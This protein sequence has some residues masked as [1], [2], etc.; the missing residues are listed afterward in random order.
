[1]TSNGSGS[2]VFRREPRVS[3]LHDPRKEFSLADVESEIRY[4]P[5]TGE[6]SR[7]CHFSLPAAAPSDI[8]AIAE[9]RRPGCPFCPGKVDTV[10]PR[11]PAGL[12]PGGRFRRGEAVV[13]PNLF[14]YDELS[15]V[16]VPAARHDLAMGDVPESLIASGVGTAR[17][18]LALTLPRLGG[19]LL[20][21]VTWNHMPPA[22]GT[23]LHPHMQVV[24]TSEP[25]G[26]VRRELAAESAWLES[27]GRPYVPALL[28]AEEAA[29]RM[30]GRTGA[31]TWYVPFAPTGVLGDCRAVLPGKSSV[32]ELDDGDVAD[33]AAG[34]RRV[35]RGF[36]ATGLWSFNLT[37]VP[38]R[39]GE[40]SGRHALSARLLPRLYIDP[41]LHTPDA[42][43]LHMLLGER[44]SMAWP[45]EVAE[46]LRRSFSEG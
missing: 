34:L 19:D 16:L 43:Y 39:S 25:G 29:G 12:V 20:G 1:M 23:Q 13:F 24:A 9:A 6:S 2:V 44:F 35:L 8:A 18:F 22:G 28:A 26:T 37:F 30:V 33:F 17:D 31:W 45:E 42:N 36:A 14:P 41:V 10:T 21:L 32:L 7:I 11:F 3:R 15:A 38:D 4:D 46:R 27:H 5:L 40:R